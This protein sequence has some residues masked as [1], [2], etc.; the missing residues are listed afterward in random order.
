MLRPP[1]SK[2]NV[3]Y[4]NLMNKFEK[5][6]NLSPSGH[7]VHAGVPSHHMLWRNLVDKV[8]SVVVYISTLFTVERF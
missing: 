5:L 8:F 6:L 4:Y 2:L 3:T 1:R 7:T